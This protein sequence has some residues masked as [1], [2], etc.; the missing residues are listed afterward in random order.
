M[1]EVG[2]LRYLMTFLVPQ[3]LSLC[4]LPHRQCAFMTTGI[5]V[6]SFTL[7]VN[8]AGSVQPEVNIA[9]GK[10]YFNIFLIIN[11]F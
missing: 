5:G 7:T 2:L 9:T 6:I 10:T 3:N 4:K 11:Y 8:E 1:T